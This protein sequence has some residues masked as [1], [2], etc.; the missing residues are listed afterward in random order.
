MFMNALCGEDIQVPI[1]AYPITIYYL[2]YWLTGCNS[3]D[4]PLDQIKFSENW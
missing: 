3:N 4:C 1:L 2:V